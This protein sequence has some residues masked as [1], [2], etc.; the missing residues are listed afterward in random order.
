MSTGC[1]ICSDWEPPPVQLRERIY[2]VIG[3]T[4]TG[5]FLGLV[6]SF[7]PIL[8]FGLPVYGTSVAMSNLGFLIG[9]FAGFMMGS[10]KE[11]EAWY[12]DAKRWIQKLPQFHANEYV[13]EEATRF[14]FGID[15]AAKRLVV[16]SRD[17]DTPI[18]L[19]LSEIIDVEIRD[20]KS[21]WKSFTIYTTRLKQ[22]S[23]TL[24]WLSADKAYK[25][26]GLLLS[27]RA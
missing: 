27:G 5:L 17:Y 7:F 9:G 8:L 11:N 13:I 4:I 19:D 25:W 14:L 21:G 24:K 15:L 20:E 12:N 3:G 18:Y 23:L 22:S 16:A 26:K 10:L 1:G 6:L 2:K